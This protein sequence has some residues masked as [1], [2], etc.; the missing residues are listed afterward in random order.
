MAAAGRASPPAV[1]PT[2]VADGWPAAISVFGVAAFSVFAAAGGVALAVAATGSAWVEGMGTEAE[3]FGGTD[4]AVGV[5][6]A[7]PTAARVPAV[8]FFGSS[9]RGTCAGPTPVGLVRAVGVVVVWATTVVLA[10]APPDGTAA[11]WVGPDAGSGCFEGAAAIDVAGV[12]SSPM[13]AGCSSATPVAFLNHLNASPPAVAANVPPMVAVV[14]AA[15]EAAEKNGLNSVG[16]GNF[17]GG[18]RSF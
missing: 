18:R 17:R 16:D 9:R 4:E 5:P 14:T 6:V 2:A 12:A 10:T 11:G 15:D 13:G 3:G 1:A 8:S 7:V